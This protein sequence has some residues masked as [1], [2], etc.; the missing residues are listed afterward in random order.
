MSGGVSRRERR[1][2]DP[3]VLPVF[4]RDHQCVIEDPDGQ[5]LGT[6]YQTFLD[7]A[8]TVELTE[9]GRAPV[10]PGVFYA[11]VVGAD[12]FDDVLQLAHFGAGKRVQIKHEPMNAQDQNALAIFGGGQKVG[13]LPGAIAEA[14]APSGTRA[15]HGVVLMEWSRDGVRN[16]I[17]VL[18]SMQVEFAVSRE[19]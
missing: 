1:A 16:G 14:L 11:R 9:D 17:S 10:L 4:L 6:G 2:A 13:Y 8:R 19:G 18:G 12:F 7:E 3:V 5:V 15:G